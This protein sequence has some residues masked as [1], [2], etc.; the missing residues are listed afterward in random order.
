MNIIIGAGGQPK[1]FNVPHSRQDEANDDDA[2]GK[3]WRS[4]QLTN[5]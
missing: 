5:R 3:S 1:K 2:P 4:E